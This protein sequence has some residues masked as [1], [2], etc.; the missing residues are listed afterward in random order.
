MCSAAL[1]T[2][3]I[4][5]RML[6]KRY[7]IPKHRMAAIA[8]P[9]KS[10]GRCK[11]IRLW[12]TTVFAR[13][14]LAER[15]RWDRRR[16][17][18]LGKLS[19]NVSFYGISRLLLDVGDPRINMFARTSQRTCS[20]CSCFQVFDNLDV[21]FTGRRVRCARLTANEARPAGMCAERTR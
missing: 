9:R 11:N 17:E 1:R 15:A 18:A 14:R 12:M 5:I 7:R 2:D 6:V 21:I 3:P 19:A 20:A 13:L 16:P 10:Q 8:Q 4:V